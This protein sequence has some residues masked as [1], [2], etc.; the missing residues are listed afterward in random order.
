MAIDQPDGWLDLLQVNISL[1]DILGTSGLDEGEAAHRAVGAFGAPVEE[2]GPPHSVYLLARRPLVGPGPVSVAE[3]ASQVAAVIGGSSPEALRPVHTLSS[4]AGRH[5]VYQQQIRGHDVV[6]GRVVAHVD[7]SAYALSGHP[8]GSLGGRDPGPPP[9]ADEQRVVDAI[10]QQFAVDPSTPLSVRQVVVPVDGDAI[11]AWFAKV[12]LDDPMVDLRVFLAAGDLSPLLVYG[13]TVPVLFGE[14]RAHRGNPRRSPEAEPVCLRDVG[15][16]PP[17][18]LGGGRVVV[19]TDLG[20]AC[21][22]SNRD[23]TLEPDDPAFDEVT[24]YH[25]TSE[26]LCFF[27]QLFAAELFDQPLFAPLRVVVHHAGSP[28]NAFFHPDR[29]VITLGDFPQGPTTARSAEIIVHE[30]GH[31]ISHAVCRLADSPA[32]QALGLGEGYSDYFA[33]SSLDDPRFGDYVLDTQ[34]GARNCAKDLKL[35]GDLDTRGRYA[36]GE[37]WANVL[38]GIRATAGSSVTDVLVATSLY[39]ATTTAAVR[40]GRAAL[41]QADAALFPSAIPGTGRHHDLIDAEFAARFPG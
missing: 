3:V 13:A 23:F 20:D 8:I 35:T 17:D 6:G 2:V 40:D 12:A 16:E 36:L 31:A 25:H 11:W 1:D 5:L 41:Q 7:T 14:G 15:P 21:T 32:P 29:G 30:V 38:W 18:G 39:F 28:S 34:D 37:A 22:R 4:M 26:A 9:D 24:A 10:R 19:T 33:C 27:R